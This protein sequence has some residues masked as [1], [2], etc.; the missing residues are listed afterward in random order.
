VLDELLG[1]DEEWLEL[2]SDD[3]ALLDSKEGLLELP[4]E[5]P[6][7]L[8]SLDDALLELGDGE[9]DEGLALDETWLE[10]CDDG[11]WLLEF[12]ELPLALAAE[13]LAEL[14]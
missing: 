11:D 8:D 13:G 14:L 12:A 9:L 6:N 2:N 3:E 10:L 7:E 1:L 4:E 5:E